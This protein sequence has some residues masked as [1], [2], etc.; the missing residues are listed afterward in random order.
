MKKKH[1]QT[2]NLKAK[3]SHNMQNAICL[4]EK[5]LRDMYNAFII[6]KPCLEYGSLTWGW[7]ERETKEP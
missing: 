2:T 5:Q 6:I 1:V 3:N 4:K 7:G